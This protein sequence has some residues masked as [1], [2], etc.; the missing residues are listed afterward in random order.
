VNV[1]EFVA[2][3]QA[4]WLRATGKP[5]RRA[6]APSSVAPVQG[7]LMI[8]GVESTVLN[9]TRF[10]GQRDHLV[11]ARGAL[12]LLEHGDLLEHD[13]QLIKVLSGAIAVPPDG[14]LVAYPVLRDN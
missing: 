4:V 12:G 1:G 7:T 10:E 13:G 14:G 9:E 11:V 8:A 3:G 6:D 2:R 5:T